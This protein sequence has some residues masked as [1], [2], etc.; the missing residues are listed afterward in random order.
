MAYKRY[1]KIGGKLYGPYEYHSYRDSD[2]SVKS[3]YVRKIEKVEEEKNRLK[4]NLL[5]FK[6]GFVILLI[7][8]A[9]ILF[10][11]IKNLNAFTGKLA[12][13]ITDK[14][15]IN[16][17]L[18]GFINLEFR[19]GE[20][21]PA[22]SKIIINFYNYTKELTLEEFISLSNV[23]LEPREEVFYTT[24]GLL[25]DQGSGLGYGFIGTKKMPID[26]YFELII[27]KEI[28]ENVSEENMTSEES[29]NESETTSQSEAEE[30][31]VSET[32][33]SESSEENPSESSTEPQEEQSGENENPIETPLESP[34]LPDSSEI[35]QEIR[36]VLTGSVI[37]EV[38][39]ISGKCDANN[40]FIYTLESGEFA[41]LVPGSVRTDNETLPDSSVNVINE[42][43]KVKVTTDY[44]LVQE[45]YGR[46]YVGKKRLV[47]LNI[48]QFNFTVNE[49][50]TYLLKVDFVY[51]NITLASVS[52]EVSFENIT[53]VNETNE[54]NLSFAPVLIKEIPDI[55]I[56][57]N[58]KYSF[59]L[60]EYFS[61]P[62]NNSLEFGADEMENITI[63]FENSIATIIPE[64]NFTGSRQ[65][66][67]YAS[68][69]ENVT[70]SNLVT[71]NVVEAK[72]YVI[73]IINKK[74]EIIDELSVNE[75]KVKVKVNRIE[76]EGKEEI[77]LILE[78]NEDKIETENNE[79]FE[80]ENKSLESNESLEEENESVDITGSVTGYAISEKKKE[81][82]SA[83]N[84]VALSDITFIQID[85]PSE[86][87]Q[88]QGIV[89]EIIA[90][91]PRA[92]KV[93]SAEITLKKNSAINVAKIGF[94]SDWNIKKFECDGEWQDTEIE[95]EQ[96]N[97]TIKFNVSSFSAYAGFSELPEGVIIKL[98]SNTE[99]CLVDC[100]AV[101]DIYI[102]ESLFNITN[103]TEEKG[104]VQEKKLKLN[105]IAKKDSKLISDKKIKLKEKKSNLIIDEENWLDTDLFDL[106]FLKTAKSQGLEEFSVE[107]LVDVTKE[108]VVFDYE[109]CGESPTTPGA[110][111][112]CV[113]GNHVEQYNV[114]EWH[115]LLDEGF[116][117]GHNIVRI[118]GKKQ[119]TLNENNVDW[120]IAMEIGSYQEPNL[121]WW[122]ASW[123]RR[124][125]IFV[126]GPNGAGPENYAIPMNITY[127]SDMQN[128]FDDLRFVD[129]DN[130]SELD[131]WI[132]EKSNGAWA[133]VWVEIKDAI[134]DSENQTVYMYYGNPQASS[135]SDIS[136]T[137]LF[138]DDFNDGVIGPEWMNNTGPIYEENGV[139][140]MNTSS[141]TDVAKLYINTTDDIIYDF[142]V[143][144][145][146]RPDHLDSG[147]Y[148]LGVAAKH[149]WDG[150]GDGY[151]VL[152]K[153]DNLSSV[154]FL[155]DWNAWGDEAYPGFNYEEGNWYWFEMSVLMGM[156]GDI[157]QGRSWQVGTE[158]PDWQITQSWSTRSGATAGVNLGY[159]SYGSFDDF[160]LRKYSGN[161]PFAY[162]INTNQETANLVV[163]VSSPACVEGEA[164]YSTIQA[165]I[166]A[167]SN[168]SSITVCPGTYTENVKVN[169]TGLKII[170]Y[171]S[172]LA[173]TIVQPTSTSNDAFEITAN[174]TLIKGFTIRNPRYGVYVNGNYWFNEIMDLNITSVNSQGINLNQAENTTIYN[175]TVYNSTSSA[176]GFYLGS[177]HNN[178]IKNCD[179]NTT[180][181]A[182]Y[183]SSS[184]DNLIE[185]SIIKTNT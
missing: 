177:A 183:L 134:S 86:K 21:Y 121:A 117:P 111:K 70:E 51:N 73:Q 157:L 153:Y 12:L 162:A 95:F 31:E 6:L 82:S 48:E 112:L 98:V 4:R 10:F 136:K 148:R 20:F 100:E 107:K 18:K 138:G 69:G 120:K 53:K 122:N 144:V 128:D 42:E 72:N 47:P 29:T 105:K 49:E 147:D 60:T 102:P 28:E 27:E 97:E 152:I 34:G 142:A 125:P 163:N 171:S 68:D 99:Q 45:G 146:V 75:S 39:R 59:D 126:W 174:S 38:K 176:Y 79:S 76:Q 57:K 175:I 83:I 168:G 124:V 133:L 178:T 155:D 9:I 7:F 5:F 164:Y 113:K 15:K 67:F 66:R 184:N 13:D 81:Y 32:E 23:E 149:R 25:D 141:Y 161:E 104:K 114:G 41:I 58:E 118:K 150:S 2:G 108:K 106:W 170:A 3:K 151:N 91:E 131:Y 154:I 130:V 182:V 44:M 185:N 159:L 33:T 140:F 30:T 109:P 179:I 61:D 156:W 115:D 180:S 8:F 132:Q 143:M 119:A 19:E 135:R 110:K 101:L 56:L 158:R 145:K 80:Q 36:D 43:N 172:N 26:V 71:I 55:T 84:F 85:K 129:D 77:N 88:K 137:F 22:N 181:Y 166:N 165:A 123:S 127:D 93:E 160:I 40:P 167:A 139:I 14:N 62:N 17:N 37:E 103:E 1:I 96:D 46:E 35:K 94:C 89:T 63:E 92:A 169:K 173:D 74:S 11:Y 78:E 54:T 116:S 52:K 16:E 64:E 65:T 87:Q 50:G 90:I 24:S